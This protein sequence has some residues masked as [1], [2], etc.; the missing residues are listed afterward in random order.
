[1]E[2]KSFSF[3]Y[4]GPNSIK[5]LSRRVTQSICKRRANWIVLNLIAS[6]WFSVA[7]CLHIFAS[8]ILRSHAAMVTLNHLNIS[9]DLIQANGY[10]S[11]EGLESFVE[12]GQ[13][14]DRRLSWR[15][16]GC[17]LKSLFK[18][19]IIFLR[20]SNWHLACLSLF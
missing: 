4:F 20:A 11:F 3:Q 2:E 16:L 19:K 12:Y 18:H 1:M 13:C 17:K 10:F 7:T 14:V 15:I 5:E 9:L 8:K 6:W